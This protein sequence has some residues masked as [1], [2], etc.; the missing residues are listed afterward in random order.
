MRAQ[1]LLLV[2]LMFSAPLS[3]CFG[4]DTPFSQTEEIQSSGTFFVTG[5]DGLPVN[6]APLPLIF[7]FS[8]VGEDGPEP[9]LGVTSSGC[10]FF[11]AMEKV[12]RSC[13]Y[14]GTW[15][16]VQDPIA[17]SP[18]TSDPYGWVDT[19]TDRIFNVQMIGLETSW[20]CW[21]DDDGETWLGN[22]HDSGTTPI[23]D[24]IKLATG[25][26][27]SMI[28][29]SWQQDLGRAV[30]MVLEVNFHKPSMKLQ[31]TIA[32]TNSQGF[33]ASQVLTAELRLR[34]VAKSSDWRP[35]MGDFMGPLLQHQMEQST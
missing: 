3:G 13:D 15:E 14:G 4:N 32:T 21:S 2:F 34:Q 18:T 12:M 26:H 7:N 25:P 9:S 28:T 23:N 27:Q 5:S 31:F 35:P 16:E 10:I 17:C 19:I 6:E 11:I 20:I 8:D 33:F 1:A 30:D 24:H 22:P 29:S